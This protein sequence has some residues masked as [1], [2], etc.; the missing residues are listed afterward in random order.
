MEVVPNLYDRGGVLKLREMITPFIMFTGGKTKNVFYSHTKFLTSSKLGRSNFAN[1][2]YRLQT[3]RNL[4]RTFCSGE[5]L[6][7]KSA[8]T[9]PSLRMVTQKIRELFVTKTFF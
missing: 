6:L 3:V 1:S 5:I 8:G 4:P 7:G 9:L 2:A